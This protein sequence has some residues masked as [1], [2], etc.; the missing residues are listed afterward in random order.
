[1]FCYKCGKYMESDAV[2][3][4]ECLAQTQEQLQNTSVQESA[5]APVDAQPTQAVVLNTQQAPT[6][7]NTKKPGN[8]AG[9]VAFVMGILSAVFSAIATILLDIAY[10]FM[11]EGYDPSTVTFEVSI[12]TSIL[13][14][15]VPLIA[16]TIVFGIRAIVNFVKAGKLKAK[17]PV[18]G[19]VMGLVGMSSLIVSVL[20]SLIDAILIL[21]YLAM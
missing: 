2:I 8:K 21:G 14:V 15:V 16:L 9:I 19:F 1:M 3:C 17:R 18:A 11:E 4:P 10:S 6:A 5:C 12:A 7:T 20:Y 13:F